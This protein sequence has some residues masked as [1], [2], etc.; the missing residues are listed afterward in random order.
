V[1]AALQQWFV[2]E[3]LA[4]E[5]ALTRYL[6]RVCTSRADV[7]DTRHDIYVKIIEAARKA[8]PLSPKSFLFTTARHLISDRVRRGRIVSLDLL[9]DLDTLNVL[10]DEIS[11]EHCAS[12]RQQLT[13]LA[14]DFDRLSDR[15]R[16]VIW[17]KR[18]EGLS[19][20]DIAQR[21]KITEGTV[22]L[23]LARGMKT[24]TRLFYGEKAV[25]GRAIDEGTETEVDHGE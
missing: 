20:K 7:L 11:P 17:M 13:R 22:E 5:A 21:L 8:R 6:A 14:L 10:V 12:M 9:G 1:D 19:Q 18:V 24:L 2:R 23:H 3:I 16:E 25:T 15:C 4:H